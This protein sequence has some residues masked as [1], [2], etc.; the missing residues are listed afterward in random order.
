MFFL[1]N[2][3]IYINLNKKRGIYVKRCGT[4][5]AGSTKLATKW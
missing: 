3:I 2:T 1:N 4:S 5:S